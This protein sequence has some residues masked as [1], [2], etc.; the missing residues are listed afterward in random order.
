MFPVPGAHRRAIFYN[1]RNRPFTFS[2]DNGFSGKSAGLPFVHTL[3]FGA[4]PPV[5]YVL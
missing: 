3:Y 5:P 2:I 4:H 1:S